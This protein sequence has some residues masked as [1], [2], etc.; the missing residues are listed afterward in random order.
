VKK[1]LVKEFKMREITLNENE[2]KIVEYIAKTRHSS[3]REKGFD[4]KQISDDSK[5]KIDLD[6][7]GGEF[8]FCKAFNIMP[9]FVTGKTDK[10]DCIMADGTTV[11]VK[12][13]VY[14]SGHL[15]APM[16]KKVGDVDIYALVIKLSESTFRIV[17]FR[18]SEK[19]ISDYGYQCHK[20]NPKLPGEGYALPQSELHEWI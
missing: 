7:F 15:L 1:I 4:D 6:G 16:T 14:R 19:L 13:T 10:D 18:G 9:S 20:D 5:Y 12:T 17:G 2:Q 8:A 3:A 11:D